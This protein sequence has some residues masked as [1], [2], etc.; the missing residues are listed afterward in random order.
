MMFGYNDEAHAASCE[1]PAAQPGDDTSSGKH[2]E[3]GDEHVGRKR[4]DRSSVK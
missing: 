3:T 4:K 1:C 2:N